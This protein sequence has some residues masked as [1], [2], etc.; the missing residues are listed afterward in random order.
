M[1]VAHLIKPYRSHGHPVTSEAIIDALVQLRKMERFRIYDL[2]S[3]L[4]VDS[5]DNRP[6]D[7]LLQRMRKLHLIEFS[8]GGYWYWTSEGVKCVASL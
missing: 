4:A 7:R 6:S 1:I 2:H 3:R 8:P 5:G